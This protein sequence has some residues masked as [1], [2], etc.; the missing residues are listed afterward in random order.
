MKLL[1][2][3][4]ALQEIV[5][6]RD[7]DSYITNEWLSKNYI[8]LLSN[9]GDLIE[10]DKP[11]ID[12]VIYYDD[13][14]PAP[15]TDFESW[16][17]YNLFYN[18][19]RGE[20]SISKWTNDIKRYHEIGCCAGNLLSHPTYFRYDGQ[21]SYGMMLYADID[22]MEKHKDIAVELDDA[23]T[24]EYINCIEALKADFIKRLTT[25]YKR[26]SHKIYAYGYWANR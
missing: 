10:V 6:R 25:Y 11:K 21:F 20:K 9:N 14:R 5:K 22:D 7:E 15:D 1:S 23:E 24:V 4:E 8:Y 2:R 3:K 12:N 26:Y 18:F 19:N 17:E 16:M 13:E